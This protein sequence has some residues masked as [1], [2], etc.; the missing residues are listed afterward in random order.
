[1]VRGSLLDGGYDC[2]EITALKGIRPTST[3]K[4]CNEAYSAEL[5]MQPRTVLEQTM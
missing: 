3:P 4:G 5:I 2:L 1:M